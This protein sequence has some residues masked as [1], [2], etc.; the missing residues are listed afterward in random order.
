M[1]MPESV[2]LAATGCA[3]P[4]NSK[5]RMACT[6]LPMIDWNMVRPFEKYVDSAKPPLLIGNIMSEV[7]GNC[8]SFTRIKKNYEQPLAAKE[9]RN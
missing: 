2:R 8:Q 4:Q 3:Q 5:S 9:L 1:A 7:E 6:K